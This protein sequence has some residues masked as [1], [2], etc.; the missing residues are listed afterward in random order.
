MIGPTYNASSARTHKCPVLIQEVQ[1]Y[2]IFQ[3]PYPLLCC[4]CAAEDDGY[5]MTYVHDETAN[6]SEFVVY[7]ARTMA[8]APVARVALP[9]RYA[10]CRAR[11]TS[12][13]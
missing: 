7:D 2:G 11:A 13:A 12:L 6:R 10:A 1:V 4:V 5:L 9:Q 3:V 8:A